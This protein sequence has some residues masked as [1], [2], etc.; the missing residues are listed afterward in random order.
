[1]DLTSKTFADSL[2]DGV[3]LDVVRVIGLEF[4]GDAG[5]GGASGLLSRT[6]TP[7]WPIEG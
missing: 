4:G 5:E 1:M 6:R 3:V 2:N 7:S